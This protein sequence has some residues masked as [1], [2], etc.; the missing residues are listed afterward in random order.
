[1]LR[2]KIVLLALIV[3]ATGSQEAL[4]ASQRYL[5]LLE[6]VSQLAKLVRP[7]QLLYTQDGV[8]IVRIPTSDVERWSSQVHHYLGAC[9]GFV[10][11]TRTVS[12]G[13]SPQ[14]I[15]LRELMRRGQRPPTYGFR[16][17]PRLSVSSLVDSGNPGPILGI[18]REVIQLQRSLGHQRE[19]R[20]G[21]SSS[22]RS[23]PRKSASASPAFAR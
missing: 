8:S 4:G 23:T 21:R 2:F 12:Q 1:M 14:A 22:S 6:H 3:L 13:M 11:V 16:L 20:E 18:S 19:R 9:G 5:L 15:V 17:R 7:E 10:D